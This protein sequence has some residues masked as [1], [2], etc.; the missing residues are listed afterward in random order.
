M[1]KGADIGLF[2]F[3]NGLL[4]PDL[5]SSP[6]FGSYTRKILI[7]MTL[8]ENKWIVI[9]DCPASFF[10]SPR[11]WGGEDGGEGG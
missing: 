5:L 7:F 10:L 6:V 3:N 9:A 1:I 11:C 8:T 4:K 2:R